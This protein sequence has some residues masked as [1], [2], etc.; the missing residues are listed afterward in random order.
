MVLVVRDMRAYSWSVGTRPE[1]TVPIQ[2]EKVA[3][4]VYKVVSGRPLAPDKYC[5]FYAETTT[6]W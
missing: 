3:P 6:V 4:G 5:F 1:D 2:I